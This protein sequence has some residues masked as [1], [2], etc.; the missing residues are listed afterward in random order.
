[1]L[2]TILHAVATV[3]AGVGLWAL[4]HRSA[5]DPAARAIVG[6]GF[7]V[8]AIPGIALYWISFLRLPVGRAYQMGNGY[9]FFGGDGIAYLEPAIAA[10]QHGI[11]AI[12]SLN[13][14]YGSP[15]F[16]KVL[17]MMILAFGSATSIGLLL[18]L[19]A[20]LA[21][22]AI[23]LR[24]PD[25]TGADPRACA[26]ALVAVSFCPSW[27]LWSLQPL[28]ETFFFLLVV[29]YLFVLA[30]WVNTVVARGPSARLPIKPL[31]L[32]TAILYA[33]AGIR[34]YFAAML[35]MGT[36]VMIG[37]LI[38]K[39]TSKRL[40]V[41]AWGALSVLILSQMIAFGAGPQLPPAVRAILRPRSLR[42]SSLR[43]VARAV[44]DSLEE[45]RQ[46]MLLYDAPTTIRIPDRQE[47]ARPATTGERFLAGSIAVFVPHWIMMKLK[48][49]NIG[50]GR[51]LWMFADL[52]TVLFDVALVW[53]L[54]VVWRSVRA[55]GRSHPLFWLVA[56]V[57]VVMCLVLVYTAANFGTLFRQRAMVYVGFIL[58]PLLVTT[59]SPDSPPR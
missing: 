46:V 39:G 22:C 23:L 42:V 2:P 21:F 14:A 57:T 1:M 16:S 17:G 12:L 40:K 4:W 44:L 19:F 55:G 58:L 5:R 10:A 11:G 48:L 36:A 18:N 7:L 52:D 9:W 30:G 45:S 6:L 59:T 20:Y 49:L 37:C 26:V 47:P 3:L 28:K 27:I 8:R 35:L 50:G 24:F 34:W 29:A 25:R 56:S 13:T 51:G 41:V 33:L 54:F 15:F 38:V 43:V 32:S 31:I 53:A